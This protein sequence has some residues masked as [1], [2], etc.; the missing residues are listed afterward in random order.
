MSSVERGGS[1]RFVPNVNSPTWRSIQGVMKSKVGSL[2]SPRHYAS[3]PR[4]STLVKYKM[5]TRSSPRGSGGFFGTKVSSQQQLGLNGVRGV[6]S[7]SLTAA[8]TNSVDELEMKFS[9]G[10]LEEEEKQTR[11]EEKDSRHC[12]KAEARESDCNKVERRDEQEVVEDTKVS[13]KDDGEVRD[14][15]LVEMRGV[16]EQSKE[17]V[18]F[19]CE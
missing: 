1:R 11:D 4:H 15:S 18:S 12:N 8:S 10:S 5:V 17:E 14:V 19:V 13:G 9:G 3:S 2:S 16:T 7:Y 6:D